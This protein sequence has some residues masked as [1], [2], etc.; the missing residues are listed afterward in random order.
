MGH[1]AITP[2][3]P[4]L[5]ILP[6]SVR[7]PWGALHEIGSKRNIVF[8]KC[9]GSSPIINMSYNHVYYALR[10]Q[11]K[12]RMW[13]RERQRKLCFQE[14]YCLLSLRLERLVSETDLKVQAARLE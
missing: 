11:P 9:C 4:G 14:L 3:S 10:A 13:T 7:S 1:I 2:W 12:T 8:V 5:K 6:E